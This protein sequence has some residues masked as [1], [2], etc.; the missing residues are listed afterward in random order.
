M[1]AS[2]G[3]ITGTATTVGTSNVTVT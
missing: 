1:N 3:L 2:T